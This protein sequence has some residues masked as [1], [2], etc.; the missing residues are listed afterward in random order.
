M[1]ASD[2][3]RHARPQCQQCVSSCMVQRM[4]RYPEANFRAAQR[5]S[6]TRPMLRFRRTSALRNQRCRSLYGQTSSS[7]G[8]CLRRN[9]TALIRSGLLIRPMRKYQKSARHGSQATECHKGCKISIACGP[10]SQLVLAP[11]ALLYPNFRWRRLRNA[12]SNAGNN[13]GSI[14][15]KSDKSC[16]GDN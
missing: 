8:T 2:F 6:E 4:W 7:K 10:T 16:C 11:F 9:G 13:V 3:T 1:A 12:I 15:P 5:R 14:G